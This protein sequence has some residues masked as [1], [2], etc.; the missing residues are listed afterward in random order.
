MAEKNKVYLPCSE[1]IARSVEN[2][3]THE[4][5]TFIKN[6]VS[7]LNVAGVPSGTLGQEYFSEVCLNLPT[8]GSV[9]HE[10]WG[11]YDDEAFVDNVLRDQDVAVYA[12]CDSYYATQ[13]PS[14]SACAVCPKSKSYRCVNRDM[15]AALLWWMMRTPDGYA[16]LCSY[17]ISE[18]NFTYTVDLLKKRRGAFKPL[19]LPLT[20]YMFDES[21]SGILCDKYAYFDQA[22]VEI[23]DFISSK[24]SDTDKD[25][26]NAT[27]TMYPLAKTIHM[28]LEELN[29]AVV[30]ALTP[31]KVV[32]YCTLLKNYKPA[33]EGSVLRIAGRTELGEGACK[34]AYRDVKPKVENSPQNENKAVSEPSVSVEKGPVTGR[35][36]S[37]LTVE[38]VEAKLANG[39]YADA[40]VILSDGEEVTT[41]KVDSPAVSIGK[42][43][44]DGLGVKAE[45]SDE[46]VPTP[47]DESKLA[48]GEAAAIVIESEDEDA[49]ED[50]DPS[51]VRSVYLPVAINPVNGTDDK[52]NGDEED[53]PLPSE[54][55]VEVKEIHSE[56]VVDTSCIYFGNN[57]LVSIPVV[58]RAELDA[59]CIGLD[60]SD[61][62]LSVVEAA[63][64]KDKRMFVELAS[65]SD[66]KM[67]VLLIY[68]PSLHQYFYTSMSDASNI[69]VL[70]KLLG[71]NSIQKLCYMSYVLL[72]SLRAKGIRVKNIHAIASAAFL[73][74]NKEWYTMEE[75]LLSLKAREPRVGV[76]IRTRDENVSVDSVALKYMHGYFRTYTR[77]K[78]LLVEAGLWLQY[79]VQ[80]RYDN[81][82]G[83]SFFRSYLSNAQGYLFSL[84]GFGRYDFPGA[85][86]N[87]FKVSGKRLML[88][89]VHSPISIEETV[90]HLLN[91]MYETGLLEKAQIQLL[92]LRQNAFIYFVSDKD[93]EYVTLRINNLV[94]S[95]MKQIKSRGVEYR[96]DFLV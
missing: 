74:A 33:A 59:F 62:Y 6:Y 76:D 95:H 23:I 73:F 79:E 47:D 75:V 58:S 77:V 15:E 64:L 46:G 66:E 93:E 96:I 80:E 54:P 45:S 1:Y 89:V 2:N 52:G 8:V 43:Y 60:R 67:D 57:S 50:S 88:T 94:I 55:T 53:N 90:R 65:V 85:L 51:A 63:V 48:D 39:E 84:N 12:T 83:V 72:G 82:L 32:E 81:I 30:D 24:M 34:A 7:L 56:R 21:L 92:S 10:R 37:E 68:V 17:G 38:F 4:I 28:C 27:V 14:L 86:P 13:D 42:K 35:S 20:G 11:G 71:Y 16:T 18:E 49:G 5:V 70:S 40:P 26:Y 9:V 91:A 25:T 87:S 44:D 3:G 78:K 22:E 61:K 29:S 31:E 36:I 19:L 69:E 41:F